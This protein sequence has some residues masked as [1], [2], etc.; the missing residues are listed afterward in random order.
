MDRRSKGV[1][2]AVFLDRDGTLMRDVGYCSDPADVELLDGVVELLPKL[3]NAGFKLVVITNQSGIGRGRF[4]E[5]AFRKVQAEL[6]NQIG[7]GVI[8]ATYF[9]ADTPENATDRRKPG[10]GML[11]EAARDLPLS[12]SESYMVGD[13]P[14]DA[15]AGARAGVKATILLQPEDAGIESESCATTV[16]KNFREVAEFILRGCFT[17][18]FRNNT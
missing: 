15:E 11:L 4:T 8:D 3:K 6:E 13:K 17:S 9:C 5:E 14:I 18:G 7:P 12:L 2:R 10:P 16:A 1:Q